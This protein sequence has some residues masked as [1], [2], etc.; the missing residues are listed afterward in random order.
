ML[1]HP[2]NS[3]VAAVMAVEGAKKRKKTAYGNVTF[4]GSNDQWIFLQSDH[5]NMCKVCQGLDQDQYFG[6]EIRGLFPYLQ[7]VGE[8]T[9]NPSVH[10]SC[11][12]ILSRVF[13]VEW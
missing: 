10:P 8:N 9:I 11:S 3:L 6:N 5:P 7:I 4:F 1:L 12:C 2:P 13:T